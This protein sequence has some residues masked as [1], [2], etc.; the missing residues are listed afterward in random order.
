[1]N[2]SVQSPNLKQQEYFLDTMNPARKRIHKAALRLFAE[3]GVSQVNV[4]DLAQAASVA[5]GTIY[6]NLSS[7]ELLFEE[8]A[9]QLAVEMLTRTVKFFEPIEDPAERLANGIRL[10][11]RRA[12]DEPDWGR[13]L[14][15]FSLTNDSL[16][17]IWNGPSMQDLISGSELGRYQ[18]RPEQLPSIVAMIGGS[19]IASMM[20]VLE[21]HKTWR[22]AGSDTAEFILRSLGIS[23]DEAQRIA[24]GE[25]QPLPE[26]EVFQKKCIIERVKEKLLPAKK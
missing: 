8:I 20:V 17:N 4:S 6:N 9:C 5:R 13:F 25:L 22:D 14:I 16:R 10:F 18:F 1:M 26:V 19:V 23:A 12:H 11:I 15:R 3:K 7:P 21:G 2:K 24:T